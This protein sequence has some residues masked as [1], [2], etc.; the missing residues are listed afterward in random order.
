M[1]RRF[2][3]LDSNH[4]GKISREEAQGPLAAAFDRYDINKD[5]FLDKN[6]LRRAVRQFQRGGLFPALPPRPPELLGPDFDSLDLNADGRLTRE[7]LKGTPFLVVFDQIDTNKDG[8]IDPKEF[9]AYLKKK[10]Q[11]KEAAEKKARSS[12]LTAFT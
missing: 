5:G 7:E 10:A 8:K 1:D 12:R 9:K 2:K 3:E 6:E 4:D 11:E